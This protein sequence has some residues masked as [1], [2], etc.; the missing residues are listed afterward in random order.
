MMHPVVHCFYLFPFLAP[1]GWILN[2]TRAAIVERNMRDKRI[3]EEVE[4]L[5]KKFAS[6]QFQIVE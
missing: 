3:C 1:K 5:W 6:T 2:E 4:D